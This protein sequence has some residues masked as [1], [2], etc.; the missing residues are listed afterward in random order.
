ML[1]NLYVKIVNIVVSYCVKENRLIKQCVYYRLFYHID[2]ITA[3]NIYINVFI[4]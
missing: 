1:V 3:Y 4:P 2:V